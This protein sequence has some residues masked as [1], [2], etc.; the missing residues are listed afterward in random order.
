MSDVK[1]EWYGPAHY[2]EPTPL[3]RAI[4]Y[5]LGVAAKEEAYAIRIITT[6]LRDA[7]IL[8][9]SPSRP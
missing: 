7:G 5:P 4:Q 2:R 9:R 6:Y 1:H 8:R 3:A